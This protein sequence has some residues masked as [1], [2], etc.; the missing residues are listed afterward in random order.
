LLERRPKLVGLSDAELTRLGKVDR[1]ERNP[2]GSLIPLTVRRKPSD[3]L[4][5]KTLSAH[6][7]R[8]YGDKVAHHHSGII[9]VMQVGR[10]GK[11]RPRLPK[12]E[13]LQ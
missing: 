2:D 8:T 3:Q 9:G 10:D 11:M 12:C 1:Y 4:V 13:D 5:L 7:P 6:F